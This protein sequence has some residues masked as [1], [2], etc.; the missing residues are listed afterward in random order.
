[1]IESVDAAIR[2]IDAATSFHE[3]TGEQFESTARES[4]G[5]LLVYY[6]EMFYAMRLRGQSLM[7]RIQNVI[8]LVSV[9]P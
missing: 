4:T 2:A 7:S 8:D 3:E 5:R 6:K 1:M 9:H